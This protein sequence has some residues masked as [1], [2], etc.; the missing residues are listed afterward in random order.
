MALDLRKEPLNAAINAAK[1][2]VSDLHGFQAFFKNNAAIGSVT[3]MLKNIQTLKPIWG[4]KPNRFKLSQPEFVCVKS[5]TFRQYQAPGY[6]PHSICV[7]TGFFAFYVNGY[8]WIFLCEK[9]F[10]LRISPIGPPTKLCP[11][12]KDNTFER[13][14]YTLADYQK[15]ALIHEMAHFYLGRSSLSGATHPEEVYRLNECVNLTAKYSLRNPMNWQYFVASK[16][17]L[18]LASHFDVHFRLSRLL[19]RKSRR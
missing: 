3:T 2:G 10:K 9:F 18:S 6:D 13:R 4:I 8:K 1:Q 5:N 12:V 17:E 14:G 7:K 16:C 15:Y 19:F 11:R